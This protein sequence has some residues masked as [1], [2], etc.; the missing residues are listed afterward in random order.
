MILSIHVLRASLTSA[1]TK[2][3]V[4]IVLKTLCLILQ[5]PEHPRNLIPELCWQ[6]YQVNWVTGTGG[7]ISIKYGSVQS[8]A[9]CLRLA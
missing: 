1:I 8:L 2:Y 4:H 7:G 6:C 9:D 5:D 3:I